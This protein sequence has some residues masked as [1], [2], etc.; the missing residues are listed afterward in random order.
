MT[1]RVGTVAYLNAKPLTWALEQGWIA[2]A[3]ARPAVPS[4]LASRL[5]AGEL[6]AA[7]VSSV[8]AV[9]E[10]TLSILPTAGCISADGPAQSVLLFSRVHIEQIRSVAL[11]ASSL[12]SVALCRVLL[13]QRYRAKPDYHSMPPS[14]PQMLAACDAALLIGDPGLAQYIRGAS[15]LPAYDV[16]DLGRAWHEWT[17]LPFVFAAWV[18]PHELV[19]SPLPA[20]LEES[21]RRLLA[22]LPTIAAAEAERISLPEPVCRHYLEH[23]IR[24]EFGPRE[25]QGFALFAEYVRGMGLG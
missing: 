5:L 22:V 10:P 20:L 6:D 9:R 8:L 25:Q 21:R 11:D 1:Y 24:Y 3:E 16:L 19:D 2:G 23:V 14:L 7:I 12:A 13:E 18:A 17:G 4:A 15:G